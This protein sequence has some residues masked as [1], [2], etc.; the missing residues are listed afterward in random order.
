MVGYLRV[1]IF[2]NDDTYC[3]ANCLKLKS[4]ISV[5]SSVFV[6][7]LYWEPDLVMG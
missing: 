2:G 1:D 5:Q 7:A 6:I 4:L 3:V